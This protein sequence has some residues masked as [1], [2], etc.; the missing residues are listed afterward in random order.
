MIENLQRVAVEAEENK[1][2][3]LDQKIFSSVLISTKLQTEDVNRH[4]DPHARLVE[5]MNGSAVQA[6]LQA[7]EIFADKTGLHGQEALQQMILNFKEIDYLWERVLLKE[8]LAR[9]SSQ[10]H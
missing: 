10:L 2:N 1:S 3:H 4:G 9:L 6:L 5:L 7:A 8:G